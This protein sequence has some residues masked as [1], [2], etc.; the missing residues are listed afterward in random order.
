M[1]KISVALPRGDSF[2]TFLCRKSKQCPLTGKMG[3]LRPRFARGG[4]QEPAAHAGQSSGCPPT[5]RS[6]G[7]LCMLIWASVES[8]LSPPC[9]NPPMRLCTAQPEGEIAALQKSY[10]RN[11]GW[12]NHYLINRPSCSELVGNRAYKIHMARWGFDSASLQ[13]SD[14]SE[15]CPHPEKAN[16]PLLMT[17]GGADTINSSYL[18]ALGLG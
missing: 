18:R 1:H 10:E 5:H 3:K 2:L 6:A 9:L 13:L 7:G 15:K 8:S 12:K 17:W 14:S 16:F 4:C 11:Y